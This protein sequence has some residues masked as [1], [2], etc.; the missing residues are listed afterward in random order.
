[1]KSPKLT[2][3][4]R[5]EVIA[6]ASQARE[7]AYA[8]YS[9]Y[10]VGAALLAESGAIYQGANVEN[11]A[12]PSTMCAERAAIFSAVSAGERGF[13]ALGLVTENGGMPCGTCRQV[14]A[15]FN[16]DMLILIAEGSGRIL[17]EITVRELLPGAFGPRDLPARL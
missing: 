14:M 8:P 10:A 16:P 2:D 1:M 13:I 4:L 3:D 5:E 12:Y 17:Q 6:Q 7:N 15:E 11:A 9:G